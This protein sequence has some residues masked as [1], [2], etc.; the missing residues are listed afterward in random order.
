[1]IQLTE[2]VTLAVAD[3]YSLTNVALLFMFLAAIILVF[4]YGY[5]QRR[6]E[7]E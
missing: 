6:A 7:T 3:I 2:T 5:L 4:V 1:M